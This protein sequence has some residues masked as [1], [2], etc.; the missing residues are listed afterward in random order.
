MA[1]PIRRCAYCGTE[2]PLDAAR[3]PSCLSKPAPSDSS[4]A[5][6]STP[7]DPEFEQ[8]PAPW[9]VTA[10]AIGTFAWVCAVVA[11]AFQIRWLHSNGYESVAWAGL[12]GLLL[13]IVRITR[14]VTSSWLTT[15]AVMFVDLVGVFSIVGGSVW[16]AVGPMHRSLV[17]MEVA[18]LAGIDLVVVA[19]VA[20][21]LGRLWRV[22]PS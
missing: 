9:V 16:I 21:L 15:I 2:T 12:V 3:C 18:C 22:E 20:W 6:G 14:A 4:L 11:Y 19:L 17:P 13:A 10:L 7:R 5:H 1:Q 8:A